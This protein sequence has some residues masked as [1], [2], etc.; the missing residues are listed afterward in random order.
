M[1]LKLNVK[2]MHCKSCEVLL[3]DTLSDI[4]VDAEADHKTGIIKI[5]FDEK[6]VNLDKIKK[7]IAECG[8]KV[9]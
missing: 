3:K 2:G 8:Y 6:K 5:N 4:G 1:Q 9:E 7:I